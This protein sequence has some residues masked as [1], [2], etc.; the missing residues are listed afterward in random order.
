M[1]IIFR[2]K[3]PGWR[4]EV[5]GKLPML[6]PFIAVTPTS[7]LQIDGPLESA[8]AISRS[9]G[10]MVPILPGDCVEPFLFEGVG[11]DV[12]FVKDDPSAHLS[13]PGGSEHRHSHG[14]ID[15]HFIDFGSNV[16]FVELVAR[17]LS[18]QTRFRFE[19]WSRKVDYRTDYL[20][21][22]DD[23]SKI[24]RNLAMTANAK[25][26]GLAAPAW[27]AKPTLIE[28]FALLKSHFDMMMKL[29]NMIVI[30]PHAKLIRWEEEIES[31][32]ARKVSRHRLSRHLRKSNAGPRIERF[33]IT[34][35]RRI[36]HQVSRLSVD[37]PENRYVKAVLRATFQ[38]IRTL[39]SFDATEDEDGDRTS[40][41]RYFESIRTE[42]SVMGSRLETLRRA[43]GMRDIGEAPTVRPQSMVLHKNPIYFQFDRISRMVNGG[44]S[45]AANSVPIGVK[46][47]ALLYEYW[48]F[49]KIIELLRK[50]RFD[51]LDQSVVKTNRFKTTVTLKKGISAAIKLRSRST[52]AAL[53]LIYNKLFDRLPTI[54]QKPDN[55]IQLASKDKF[56]IL[57]AKY[58]IQFDSDYVRQ[59]GGVGPTTEDINT[60][61]RYRDAIALPHPMRPDEY[62]TGVVIGAAVLFPF[63]DED[64]Y[65]DHR[66]FKSL[67]A[68]EI[69]GLP[70]LPHSTKLVEDKLFAL[71]SAFNAAAPAA[72]RGAG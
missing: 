30:R 8:E 9:E 65:L 4:L 45:F 27:D 5:T 32:K 54:N 34:L 59:Y 29:A 17:T 47:T 71:L 22:R 1:P 3:G 12:Y 67:S 53:F 48:C 31:G 10:R 39:L 26:F 14:N 43:P 56:Y 33:A 46:D 19:V 57:D 21:M 15:H 64:A 61:H 49:L 36:A 35:P 38:N 37:T 20:E 7:E 58:R 55:V 6:P 66:F 69:G 72:V 52:G 18:A 60:M 44:L 68:V 23:V 25:T 2:A 40:E 16:G 51:L 28:W 13:L 62:R 50:Q 11:Y 41:T 24:L 42:L 70:F 63:C